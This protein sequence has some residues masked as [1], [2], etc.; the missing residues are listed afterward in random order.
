MHGHHKRMKMRRHAMRRC[1]D[2]GPPMRGRG[3]GR[4][5]IIR[6]FLDENPDIAEKFIRYGIAEM[7][8]RDFTD[9]EI[10][11]HLEEMHECGHMDE[12]DIDSLLG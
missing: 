1:A 9:E 3:R 10:R 11:A 4:G 7:R 2:A 6:G 5:A 8:E 12:F